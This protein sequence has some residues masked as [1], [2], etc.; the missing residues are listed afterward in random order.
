MAP[1][2]SWTGHLKISLISIPV[3]LYTVSASSSSKVRLNMLHKECLQRV[4]QQQICETHGVLSRDNIVKGYEF[5]KDKY[6]VVDDDTLKNIRLETTKIIDINQYID[7]NDVDPVYYNANYYVAPD[8]PVAMEAFRVFRETLNYTGKVAVG[9]VVLSGREHT[10]QIAPR[11][12]GLMLTT[13]RFA[14]EVKKPT[15]YFED[16]PETDVA[17]EQ[18]ELFKQL[19]ESNIAPLDMDSLVDRYEEALV[20]VIKAKIDGREPEVVQEQETAK[21]IDF[22]EALRA[23]VQAEKIPKKPPAASAPSKKKAAKKKKTG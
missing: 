9:H 20:E 23:S 13:L 1:R 5:E 7:A 16:I 8:G 18:L 14:K 11:D 22:M 15:A 4:R 6:V 21:A 12:K 2:A 19:I 17:P 10:V 3:R